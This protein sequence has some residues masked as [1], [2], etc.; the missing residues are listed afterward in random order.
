MRAGV[1]IHTRARSFSSWQGH[2]MAGAGSVLAHECACMRVLDKVRLA[3]VCPDRTWARVSPSFARSLARAL[4]RSL[5][6]SLPPSLPPSLARS[7]PPSLPLA[8]LLPVRPPVPL[9]SHQRRFLALQLDNACAR[10]PGW[11]HFLFYGAPPQDGQHDLGDSLRSHIHARL[12]AIRLPFGCGR[13]FGC[14]SQWAAAANLA[15]AATWLVP[16]VCLRP[17]LAAIRRLSAIWL[18][19]AHSHI[20][21]HA[22]VRAQMRMHTLPHARA[23]MRTHVPAQIY[24]QCAHEPARGAHAH[25]HAREEIHILRHAYARGRTQT[26]GFQYAHSRMRPAEPRAQALPRPRT[27]RPIAHRRSASMCDWASMAVVRPN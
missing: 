3:S 9:L 21:A 26:C 5:P 22:H 20:H 25:A 11:L 19:C 23:H 24:M 7:L 13:E 17:R 4:A 15:A 12:A 1:R 8:P 14:G 2:F 16:R 18:P 6:R 27:L 10:C